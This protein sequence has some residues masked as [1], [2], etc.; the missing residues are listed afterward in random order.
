[1]SLTALQSIPLTQR[2]G[3]EIFCRLGNRDVRVDEFAGDVCRVATSLPAAR[4]LINIAADRYRFTVLLFA[5]AVAG[6]ETLLPGSREASSV[7][8]LAQDNP[9]CVTIHDGSSELPG[10][11]IR[12]ENAESGRCDPPDLDAS[13]GITVFTSGSTGQ[14]SS[15]RKDWRLLDSFRHL[16]ASMLNLQHP[17]TLIAT[18]PSWHM[19]G[20][21]WALLL[22][23]VAPVSLY[24]G[25]T[26]YPGD[27]IK[28]LEQHSPN[29]VLVSTPVHLRALTRMPASTL[30]VATTL[31]ATAP[32]DAQF[33]KEIEA[34]LNS[35][36]LEIYGCSE[37]GSLA[38]R[39]TAS[40]EHWRFFDAF[41]VHLDGEKLEVSHPL[42]PEAVVLADVFSKQSDGYRL[43]GRATDIVKVGGKRE[44]LARLN[45][46]LQGIDGVEDGIFYRAADVG[47]P[48]TDRL[49]ALAVSPGLTSQE[50]RR[51][52]A[53]NIESAFLPRPLTL[54]DSLPRN[55]TGKLQQQALKNLI[56]QHRDN[57]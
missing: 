54:V 31:C 5:A 22:P 23:T 4:T 3:A 44:S 55:A 8:A 34:Y 7:A 52:L 28:L 16:H 33:A 17:H 21:E 50:L 36:L 19:Y 15:H 12:W 11:A 29:T 57:H 18:V 26:F 48:P 47:L 46:L 41:A 1:M 32:I 25:N 14:A 27:L 6:K 39:L 2:A 13:A 24:C 51:R 38:S 42:L 43:D 53:A 10:V 20:F 40:E 9:G 45:L 49:S 30:S 37:I 56:H 35:Q